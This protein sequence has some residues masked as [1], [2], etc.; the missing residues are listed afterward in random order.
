MVSGDDE[1]G[2]IRHGK[3]IQSHNLSNKNTL[4]II[5][6]NYVKTMQMKPGLPWIN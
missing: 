1:S 2:K 5:I 4:R 3:G 6:Y